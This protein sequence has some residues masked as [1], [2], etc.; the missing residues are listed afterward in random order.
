MLIV[1]ANSH[2]KANLVIRG[3]PVDKITVVNNIPN[4]DVFNRSAYQ[5]ERSAIRKQFTLI[6]PG[7]IAPR[8]GLDVPI[9][10]LQQ[11][12]TKIP[13]IRLLIIGPHSRI[14]MS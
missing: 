10:A 7:T 6:F 5:E 14:R 2:F 11:L 4:S 3:I 13:E 1:T 8:Y 12:A 9:R